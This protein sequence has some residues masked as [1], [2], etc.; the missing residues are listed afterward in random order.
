L[1]AAFL[2]A[3]FALAF[4]VDL[5]PFAAPAGVRLGLLF[6]AVLLIV[7]LLIPLGPRPDEADMHVLALVAGHSE[8]N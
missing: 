8:R 4:A 6:V 7:I 3:L 5:A 2:L 1:F